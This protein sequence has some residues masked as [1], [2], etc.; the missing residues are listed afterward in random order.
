MKTEGYFVCNNSETL[1]DKQNSMARTGLLV[2]TNL[3]KM[4]DNLSA[5]KKYV[6]KTLYYSTILIK[7]SAEFNGTNNVNN[8][9]KSN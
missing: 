6:S 9:N 8:N 1:V 3:S 4:F 7:N 2:I 5:V